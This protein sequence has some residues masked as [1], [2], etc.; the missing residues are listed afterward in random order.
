MTL[1]KVL[2]PL[3]ASLKYRLLVWLVP[4]ALLMCGIGFKAFHYVVA[5]AVSS[6]AH[7]FSEKQVQYDR[8]R[9][10]RPILRELTLAKILSDSPVIK[11]WLLNE[12][13]SV[14]KQQAMDE[15][16]LYRQ[17][18]H[19][20]SYF[21]VVDHSGHYYFN[22][23]ENSYIDHPL[24]YTISPEQSKDAWYYA[25][26]TNNRKCQINVNQDDV[27]K[28]TKVW[29]NCL[30]RSDNKIMG[31][32]GTGLDL[33]DFIHSVVNVQQQGVSNI[34][35]NRNGAIQA[36]PDASSIDFAS[37]THG[38]VSRKSIFSLLDRPEDRILLAG[39]IKH[40]SGDSIAVQPVSI[41]GKPYMIAIAGLQ[42]IGW[43]NVTMINLNQLRLNRYFMP[44]AVLFGLGI[45]LA[46]VLLAVLMN[47]LVVFRIHRLEKN[48]Q[49][50]KSG[51]YNFSN[52]DAEPDEIGRLMTSFLEM[53]D[54]VRGYAANLEHTVTMRTAE[55]QASLRSARKLSL[56]IEQAGESIIITDRNGIIEYANPAF[57]SVTGYSAEDAMGQTPRLLKSGNQDGAFYEAMWKT[58]TDG[59]VWHGKVIDKRKD[60]SFYPAMLTISPIS[61]DAS[62]AITHFVGIQSDLSVL[63]DMENR[64]H[65]AQKMEAVGT[66]VG[67]IAHNFNNMLAGMTGNLYLAK[68]RV[69][70]QPDVVQR[71]ANVEE[72]S[73]HAAEMIQQ[74]LAFARKGVVS[75]KEMPLTPFISETL[76]LLH[77]SVPENITV[78]QNVCTDDLIIKGDG[79]QL[80]QVL[81]NLVNNARDAVEGVDKP[82]ITIKLEP[83][84]VDDA[85][86]EKHPYFKA[87]AYARLCVADNGTGI[88]E[89]HIE[90]LF[91]PFFTTKEQ[92]QGT[93][94]G[95]SM[96]YGAV[97][98]HHGFVEVESS[99]GE[100]STF[101]IY[102]PLLETKDKA[103]KTEQKLEAAVGQGELILLADDEPVIREV[104]AEVLES[105]G[106]RVIMAA[107]GLEAFELFKAHE[108]DIAIA[109]LDLIMPRMGG[110]QLAGQIRA[111]KPELPVIFLTGYD[112]EHV[113]NGNE[114]IQLSETFTKPVNFDAL[115]HSIRKMLD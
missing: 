89:R 8:E 10:L 68:K 57:T 69:Q 101:H 88:S 70:A 21:I 71:L 38:V 78:H 24:R 44:M 37:L 63:E 104:M 64:F 77:A 16:E 26:I 51:D 33:T 61:D 106:Y 79:T 111:M 113:L 59:K 15:L 75:I 105:I 62:G 35:I 60:G 20:H 19:D 45:F 102:I 52:H 41:H 86:I 22:N 83:F 17:I 100:G 82:C 72:L 9:S 29:I 2:K 97:K 56:A 55:L 66:M 93:G 4:L 49:Q 25:T 30:V 43:Y 36:A 5:D 1:V 46:L 84:Q 107:D 108:Q 65:Q 18:F 27:L 80:H 32:I 47:R 73:L 95:L 39:M 99:S 13:N 54:T 40:I 58:I 31:V 98:T 94:L 112:K 34:Y 90:H 6:I 74:L 7:D 85:F 23:K 53:A 96:V 91:E 103:V 76:K 50:M 115:S 12:N 109:L 87:G 48:V 110:A 3:R 81:V 14:L 42:K 114:K 92:G 28:A 11:S 67:G